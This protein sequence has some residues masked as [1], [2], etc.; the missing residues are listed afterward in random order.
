MADSPG[1]NRVRQGLRDVPLPDQLR[2]P[3]RTVA[4]RDDLIMLG[5]CHLRDRIVRMFL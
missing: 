2:K 3:L 4:S 5:L 1:L